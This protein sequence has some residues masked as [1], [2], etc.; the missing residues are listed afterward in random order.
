VLVLLLICVPQNEVGLWNEGWQLS[1]I[2][3]QISAAFR[4][5]KFG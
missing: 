4:S 5:F 1:M 3:G 2:R